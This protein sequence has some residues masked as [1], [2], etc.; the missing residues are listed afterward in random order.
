MSGQAM[1]RSET[2]RVRSRAALESEIGGW[3]CER[4]ARE[5][6][7]LAVETQKVFLRVQLGAV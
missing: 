1:E 3:K 2:Q 5:L 6:V 4:R 7:C